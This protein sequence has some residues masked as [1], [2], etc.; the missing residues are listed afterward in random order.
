MH[1]SALEEL[2][3]EDS[4]YSDWNYIRFDIPIQ[5]LPQALDLLHAKKFRGV[6]LTIPHKVEA[7]PLVD[8][9]DP[10]AQSIGAINTLC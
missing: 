9:V 4:Q 5:E 2:A 1:N 6:N 10:D 3:L 7:L 8:R